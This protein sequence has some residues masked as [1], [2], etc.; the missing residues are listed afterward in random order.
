MMKGP[1]HTLELSWSSRV[2]P[3]IYS[4]QALNLHKRYRIGLAKSKSKCLQPA[5]IERGVKRN[6]VA[7]KDGTCGAFAQ[8]TQISRKQ[9]CDYRGWGRRVAVDY[10]LVIH[11]RL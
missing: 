5:A 9:R 1:L 2:P 10:C 6:A 4:H 11:I 3:Q 8:T 7:G